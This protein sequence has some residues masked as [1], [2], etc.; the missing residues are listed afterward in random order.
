MRRL[1]HVKIHQHP[2]FLNS[3]LTGTSWSHMQDV[4]VDSRERLDTRLMSPSPTTVGLGPSLRKT[5]HRNDHHPITWS[6]GLPPL[7]AV[8]VLPLTKNTGPEET[9]E[10]NTHPVKTLILSILSRHSSCQDTHSVNPVKTLILSRHSFCQDNHS[11]N[12]VK[13][14]ILSSFACNGF[15]SSSILL[16]HTTELLL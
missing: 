8:V 12:P 7:T 16:F 15:V 13:T 6:H 3:M 14:L 10:S 2:S 4:L 1:G 5:N 9:V 11:V